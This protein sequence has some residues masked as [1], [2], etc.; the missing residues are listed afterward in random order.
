MI[1][2]QTAEQE[3]TTLPSPASGE[4]PNWAALVEQIRA[5][6]PAGLEQLY[7]VFTTGIR[8]YLCRQ[9]GPQ[10]LDDKVHDAFLTITQSIR[11]GALREPERLMGY[12]R[13]IIRRQVAGYIGTVVDARRNYVDLDTSWALLRDHQPDPERQV[14]DRQNMDVAMRVLNSLPQRDREVLVRFYLKEQTPRQICRDMVLTE[15]QFRL[16]KSRAKA[17]FTEL[18][19][20]RLSRRTGFA[21]TSAVV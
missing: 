14:I 12:V 4:Q 11:R 5:D 10:D 19:R 13:T 8:F 18:G 16:V 6:D 7:K 17:R 15:T 9:L 3:S 20:A 1:D 2:S 21:P